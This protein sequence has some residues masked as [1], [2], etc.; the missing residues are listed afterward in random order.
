MVIDEKTLQD[1]HDR[2]M[3]EGRKIWSSLYTPTI[4]TYCTRC[5]GPLSKK[6]KVHCITDVSTMDAICP[7]CWA[8]EREAKLIKEVEEMRKPKL[9][10][11]DF[12]RL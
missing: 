5:P 3:A 2:V 8:E 11:E 1:I 7:S 6:M 9:D 4:L 12:K 10:V